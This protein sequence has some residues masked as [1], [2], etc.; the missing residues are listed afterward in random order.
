MN[1][2]KPTK[3]DQLI[4]VLRSKGLNDQQIQEVVV[5]VNNMTAEQLYNRMFMELT[6]KD[7]DYIEK[8]P[9]DQ[10]QAEVVKRFKLATNKTPEQLA[11]EMIDTFISGLVQGLEEEKK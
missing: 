2:N 9:E 1:E 3:L 11:D 5:N 8:L 4:H 7:L 10:I 6:D